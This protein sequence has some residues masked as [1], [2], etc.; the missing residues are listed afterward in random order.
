MS[1][2]TATEG[3]ATSVSE[4]ADVEAQPS[5]IQGDGAA[6]SDHGEGQADESSANDNTDSDSADEDA[7]TEALATGKTEDLDADGERKPAKKVEPE[8]DEPEDAKKPEEVAKATEPELSDEDKKE[9]DDLKPKSARERRKFA[10]VLKERATGRQAM[11]FADDLIAHAKQ[12]GLETSKDIYEKFEEERYLRGLDNA[13]RAEYFR[14]MADEIH[15]ESKVVIPP[16]PVEIPSNLQEAVDA[17]YLTKEDAED[18]ARSRSEK[19]AAKEKKPDPV[20]APKPAGPSQE[21]RDKGYAAIAKLASGYQKR[22][23]AEWDSISKDIQA[24]LY[25]LIE[26]SDPKTWAELSEMVTERVLAKRQTTLKKPAQTTRPAQ[27]PPKKSADDLSEA[28]ELDA[29][30][31]GK[32]L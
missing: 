11:K 18:L 10:S 2:P 1:D 13:K 6:D 20:E 14:K 30:A 22:F 7:L 29:L 23:G 3:D 15:P 21:A 25:P 9:L 26:G 19:V 32:L 17:G 12:S 8:A 5:G 27:A 24:K 4:P 31:N 16:K 28:D